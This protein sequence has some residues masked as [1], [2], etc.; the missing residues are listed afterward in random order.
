[1]LEASAIGKDMLN[2]M[3]GAIGLEPIE[4]VWHNEYFDEEKLRI[5]MSDK[6]RL[7]ARFNFGTGRAEI[8]CENK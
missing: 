4:V 3:R 1:M 2:N 6:Y 5:Y 7:H 8:R